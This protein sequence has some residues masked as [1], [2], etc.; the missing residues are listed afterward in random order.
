M[1]IHFS[2]LSFEQKIIWVFFL[3]EVVLV[4]LLIIESYAVKIW[5][6]IKA[7]IKK[8][9]I[10][11]I[12]DYYKSKNTNHPTP[13]LKKLDLIFAELEQTAFLSDQEKEEYIKQR[14][15]PRTRA[16]IK[17]KNFF[18]RFYLI[19]SYDYHITK[20]DIPN[21]LLLIHDQRPIISI[22]ATRLSHDLVDSSIYQAIIERIADLDW[23][24]Q[25]LYIAQLPKNDTL[26]D[27]LKNN[28]IKS[29]SYKFKSLCYNIV[30]HCGSREDFYDL[31][32]T[33]V[34]RLD[35]QCQLSA[36]RVLAQSNPE[37][38]KNK[39]LE[40]L[41]SSNWLVR[42]TAIQSLIQIK[43]LESI[44]DLAQCLD[45]ENYWIR[46]NSIIA[47]S[48]ISDEGRLLVKDYLRSEEARHQPLASYFLD[49][50]RADK[51]D[52]L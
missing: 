27:V 36:I 51:K 3:I 23:V 1:I 10:V 40:L 50:N 25:K 21:L 15:L 32:Q 42:N 2:S 6:L 45:D 16:F 4:T 11:A 30:Y 48:N 5:F 37:K 13:Y 24:T 44:N 46:A 28:M 8:K 47:L 9:R 43:A 7:S 26:L 34:D 33:D 49:T 29:S 20:E 12:K 52:Y 22:N 39:L 38:A 14:L 31:A 35:K 41:K 18:K 19:K 17:S